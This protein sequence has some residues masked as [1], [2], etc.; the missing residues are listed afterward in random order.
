VYEQHKRVFDGAGLRGCALA[1]DATPLAEPEELLR[2]LAELE[3]LGERRSRFVVLAAHELRAP[4]TVIHG[5]AGTLA[6]RGDELPGDQVELL[7][8]LLLE[9]T[10]KLS[11]LAEQ[12]LDLSR[13]DAEVVHIERE[14][15]AIRERIEE[16]VASV[17]GERADDVQIVV[18]PELE[19]NVDPEALDRIVGNL[20]TNALRYGE[21]PVLISAEQADTHFRLTVEDHGSGVPSEFRGRLFERFSREQEED[22]TTGSGLGLAIAQQYAV[23]HGGRIVYEPAQPHGAR[24]RVVIPAPPVK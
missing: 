10:T 17:A 22:S 23:A 20:V 18:A 7:R 9:H 13:L 24:F 3:R 8:G 15:L 2:R 19:A 4:V 21:A 11:R 12:L 14:R 1:V 5:I 6:A 16:L